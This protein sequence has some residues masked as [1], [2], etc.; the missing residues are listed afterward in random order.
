[1]DILVFSPIV[2]NVSSQGLIRE[3]KWKPLDSM[4]EKYIRFRYTNGCFPRGYLHTAPQH[5]QQPDY[6][7]N[8]PINMNDQCRQVKKPDYKKDILICQFVA[9]LFTRIAILFLVIRK[10]RWA[11]EGKPCQ[12]G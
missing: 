4:A 5:D 10:N 7:K 11:P 3:E 12:V 9:S 2:D 8:Y 1:M 6:T